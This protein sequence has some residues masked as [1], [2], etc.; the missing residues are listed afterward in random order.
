M[1]ECWSHFVINTQRSRWLE[2]LNGRF[3]RCLITPSL[4]Q[5]NLLPDQWTDLPVLQVALLIDF[6]EHID[7]CLTFLHE[8]LQLHIFGRI[9]ECRNPVDL[10][11]MLTTLLF[12]LFYHWFSVY[13]VQ[14][15]NV[16]V[17]QHWTVVSL[18]WTFSLAENSLF[19]Y[20][21]FING[22]DI[23]DFNTSD[24]LRRLHS[25]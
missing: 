1:I 2:V 15:A 8:L 6:A 16:E 21:R 24:R 4:W 13:F 19:F 14:V 20:L 22:I 25:L 5:I 17:T 23:D 12:N 9:C 3:I 11:Y 7:A 10:A 18:Q